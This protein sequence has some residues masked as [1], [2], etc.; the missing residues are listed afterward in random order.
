V[1]IQAAGLR[2]I[3]ANRLTGFIEYVEELPAE[4]AAALR[5]DYEYVQKI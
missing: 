4:D 5:D 3:D 2:A 1:P